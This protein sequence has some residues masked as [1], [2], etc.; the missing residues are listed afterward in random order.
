MLKGTP[1]ADY[2]NTPFRRVGLHFAKWFIGKPK[3]KVNALLD[4][5]SYE[6]CKYKTLTIPDDIYTVNLIATELGR[7]KKSKISQPN[8]GFSPL[9]DSIIDD[10]IVVIETG[11]DHTF[12]DIDL[13]NRMVVLL[14]HIVNRNN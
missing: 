10:D 14:Q 1:V 3:I 12:E 7:E 2:L 5:L 9:L 8:D 6:H 11:I 13:N 4:D